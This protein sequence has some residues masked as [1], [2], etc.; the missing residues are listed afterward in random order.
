[1]KILKFI[2]G[3]LII[4]SIIFV[5]F[6]ILFG[7]GELCYAL[8]INSIIDVPAQT[9][10]TNLKIGG[11]FLIIVTLSVLFGIVSKYIGDFIFDNYK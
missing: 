2:T 9:F 6:V 1:M 10:E 5:F 7:I 3:L 4:V 11:L 8:N